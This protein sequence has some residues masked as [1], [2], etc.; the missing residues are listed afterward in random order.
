LA[1]F[2]RA[3]L[4]AAAECREKRLAAATQQTAHALAVAEQFKVRRAA[5]NSSGGW[6][7]V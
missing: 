1:Q 5:M 7:G 4:V 2:G 6:M 3:T